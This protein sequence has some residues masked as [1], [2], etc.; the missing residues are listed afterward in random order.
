MVVV[1]AAAVMVLAVD[2]DR[3]TWQNII[4]IDNKTFY[5]CLS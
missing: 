1:D 3:G 4:D 2:D 5:V